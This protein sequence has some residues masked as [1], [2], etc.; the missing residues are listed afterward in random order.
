MPCK[1]GEFSVDKLPTLYTQVELGP[2][3]SLP[4]ATASLDRETGEALV[5][6]P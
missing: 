6:L 5:L 3:D 1:N 4:S 2:Q